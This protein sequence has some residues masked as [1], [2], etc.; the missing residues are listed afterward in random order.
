MEKIKD[1]HNKQKL[2]I[3]IALKE[4]DEIMSSLENK[5]ETIYINK[6]ERH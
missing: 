5:S 4:R 3:D 1:W 6:D 2:L